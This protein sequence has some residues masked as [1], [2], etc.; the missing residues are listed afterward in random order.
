MALDDAWDPSKHPRGGK[1][2]NA[3]E[4]SEAPGGGSAA[5]GEAGEPEPDPETL[6]QSGDKW[7]QETAK[8]LATEYAKVKG[9]VASDYEDLFPKKDHPLGW[10][11]LPES[12]RTS[13]AIAWKNQQRYKIQDDLFDQWRASPEYKQAISAQVLARLNKPSSYM[14]DSLMYGPARDWQYI[15]FKGSD[16]DRVAITRDIAKSGVWVLMPDGT[17]KV[18][19]DGL[20]DKSK[21]AIGDKLPDLTSYLEHRAAERMADWPIP[22]VPQYLYDQSF[23]QVQG[24]W[25]ALS[26]PAKFA[27]TKEAGY[28]GE[29]LTEQIK[30]PKGKLDPLGPLKG[31]DDSSS[32]T[33]YRNSQK[34]AKALFKARVAKVA[35]E[36]GVTLKEQGEAVWNQEKGHYE[37]PLIGEGKPIDL[38]TLLSDDNSLWEDWKSS[39][40]GTEAGWLQAAIAEELGGRLRTHIGSLDELRQAA[41]EGFPGGFDAIKAIVR[42][43]WET[44]QY[45]LADAGLNK[46]NLYRTYTPPEEWFGAIDKRMPTEDGFEAIPDLKL[47]RNG[48]AS[49]STDPRIANGWNGDKRVV[50]R[51]TVPRTSVVSIPAF[52]QN[53]YSEHE[54]IVAGTAWDGWDAWYKRV[55][56]F[57]EVPL[58]S[59]KPVVQ[60]EPDDEEKAHIDA[61]LWSYVAKDNGYVDQD[62][63]RKLKER[64]PAFRD[65]LSAKA[66]DG[67]YGSRIMSEEL[68]VDWW[69]VN[70]NLGSNAWIDALPEADRAN[71][72]KVKALMLK[73]RADQTA[74]QKVKVEAQI[75]ADAEWKAK[76]ATATPLTGQGISPAKVDMLSD[77]HGVDPGSVQLWS[78]NLDAKGAGAVLHDVEGSTVLTGLVKDLIAEKGISDLPKLILTQ[79]QLEDLQASH[80]KVDV[81]K[82]VKDINTYGTTAAL[83]NAKSS[84]GEE[85]QHLVNKLV[86]MPVK[87][88][89]PTSLGSGSDPHT[90]TT[91]ELQQKYGSAFNDY[92]VEDWDGYLADNGAAK[93]LANAG[94]NG[95]IRDFVVDLIASHQGSLGAPVPASQHLAPMKLTAKHVSEIV[96]KVQKAE[97]GSMTKEAALAA[98]K[99]MDE[100][101]PFAVIL[102]AHKDKLPWENMATVIAL[103]D[104]K[105]G[106]LPILSEAQI[107]AIGSEPTNA[108]TPITTKGWYDEVDKEGLGPTLYKIASQ[109]SAQSQEDIVSA[110][111]KM[112][113]AN[114]AS[115]ATAPVTP[116][117]VTLKKGISTAKQNAI[118][119]KL[120]MT[121]AGFA[122]GKLSTGMVKSWSD[123]IDEH[124]LADTMTYATGQIAGAPAKDVIDAIVAAKTPKAKKATAGAYAGSA[125]QNAFIAKSE[126]HP[127]AYDYDAPDGLYKDWQDK[128]YAATPQGGSDLSNAAIDAQKVKQ[129]ASSAAFK[130]WAKK[131]YPDK[132]ADLG[133]WGHEHF[134]AMHDTQAMLKAAHEPPPETDALSGKYDSTAADGL[135]KN[136]KSQAANYAENPSEANH[137]AQMG[138]FKAWKAK[139]EP[140]APNSTEADYHAPAPG[141]AYTPP[142]TS[143]PTWTGGPI[144]H[145]HVT[146]A[147][148]HGLTA[149]QQDLYDTATGAVSNVSKLKE[150]GASIGEIG[151]AQ[152][153][154]NYEYAKF[155]W[156]S[157]PGTNYGD[158]KIEQ[159]ALPFPNATPM[160]L[161]AGG[162]WV[163]P[164]STKTKLGKIL[165]PVTYQPGGL[166][167]QT[168]KQNIAD[169]GVGTTKMQGH[170]VWNTTAERKAF[171]DYIDVLAAELA[172]EEPKLVVKPVA[173]AP[174][175]PKSAKVAMAQAVFPS[176][177]PANYDAVEDDWANV[178]KHK[179]M[180]GTVAHAD[181]I[182]NKAHMKPFKDWI[183]M[184]AAEHG[185]DPNG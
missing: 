129:D 176:M 154:A 179:G 66:K 140:E 120:G 38:E 108:M 181:T 49:T 46:L 105:E 164:S 156:N 92:T 54:V 90:M 42:A 58:G 62:Q 10:A 59:A 137:A 57:E 151:A 114:E 89:V 157:I 146:A 63:Y 53:I 37:T 171:D 127:K 185:L 81:Q 173:A 18:T 86:T 99:Q 68:G 159:D 139:Y 32:M 26:E 98:N 82:W 77:K 136:W 132:K 144:T 138:A 168:W 61:T 85:T 97:G 72:E 33:A 17:L 124:G 101:G 103:A 36:R 158:T 166:S 115:P 102:K 60:R 152:Q 71:A 43:K 165:Y 27:W 133:G 30:K 161:E 162:G 148:D 126:V 20:S 6:V 110:I 96:Q 172:A 149:S 34:I 155:V 64:S 93:T 128:L 135:Y 2:E 142:Q 170:E 147:I 143:E 104:A 21:A 119:K 183:E 78:K 134:D 51:A 94:E 180:A 15:N 109:Y 150:A 31:D 16:D 40:T 107:K 141:T 100:I 7:N 125:E 28:L 13:G 22:A 91:A 12:V 52:G 121:V 11:D 169:Q 163:A 65:Y 84:Y 48:A 131:Y 83:A 122:G 44:T 184:L 50:I 3:G 56:T 4:F 87:G 1:Q 167:D 9:A 113:G 45:L 74:K 29:D 75:K 106:V 47:E 8:R 35:A 174:K 41:D 130:V 69:T 67:A 112:Y 39:S 118:A 76:N 117:P 111:S 14:E 88:G 70:D 79:T 55:P 23:K 123:Y 175:V 116:A 80:P 177:I 145:A 153:D 5:E 95:P 178:L 160:H 73:E 25:D 19:L 182:L 24:L